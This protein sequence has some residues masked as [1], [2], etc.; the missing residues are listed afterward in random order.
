MIEIEG[1]ALLSVDNGSAQVIALLGEFDGEAT[2]DFVAIASGGDGDD[3]LLS[4]PPRGAGDEWIVSLLSGS[5]NDAVAAG[6]ISPSDDILLD[7]PSSE[8]GEI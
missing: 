4:D 2:L 8:D 7:G 1:G 5:S 6:T 3:T